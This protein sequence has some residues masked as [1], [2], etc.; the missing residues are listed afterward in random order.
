[1]DELLLDHMA[2]YWYSSIDQLDHDYLDIAW[3]E[4]LLSI[5]ILHFMMS[6]CLTNV[7]CLGLVCPDLQDKDL[8]LKKKRIKT[9]VNNV[10][11]Q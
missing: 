3:E 7:D 11:R 1:M 9:I 10:L 6:K 8:D 4:E 2:M 5:I